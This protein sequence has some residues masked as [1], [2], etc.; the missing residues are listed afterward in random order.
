MSDLITINIHED[1]VAVLTLNRPEAANALSKALLDELNEAVIEINQNKS[2]YCTVITGAGK[3]AF[4]AGAD[5]KERK[6]MSEEEVMKAVR[7]IGE[8]VTAIEEMNMPVIAA[9][10]GAAYG[11]GLELALACDIRIAAQDVKL[12]LTETSL[13]IIP[14]AGGTQRLPRL[15]GLGHA[16]RLIFTAKPIGVSEALSIG[17]IEETADQPDLLAEALDMAKTIACNGPIALKQAKI[18]IN[19]GMQTDIKQGVDIERACYLETIPT[20]DRLEGLHAFKEKRKP[21]YEGI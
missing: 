21:V 13:A 20:K 15:V 2:I 18:A 10:N 3:K 5:L 16:K 9:I 1:H 4:C 19:N 11:G 12:G 8:T 7:Y 6:G 14:G 17:L